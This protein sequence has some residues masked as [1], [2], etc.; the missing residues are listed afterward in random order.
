MA[1]VTGFQ[2]DVIGVAV[3][4]QWGCPGSELL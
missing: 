2:Q 3:R 1:V 4:G